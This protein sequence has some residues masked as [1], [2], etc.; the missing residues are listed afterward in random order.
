MHEYERREPRVKWDKKLWSALIYTIIIKLAI[1][2]WT[3]RLCSL[4]R[5]SAKERREKSLIKKY[6]LEA[7]KNC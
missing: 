7:E 2:E 4:L 5:A 1:G 3:Q 6:V